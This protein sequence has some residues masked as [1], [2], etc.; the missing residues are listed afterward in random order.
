MLDITNVI[1]ISVNETPAGLSEYQVNNVCLFTTDA[2]LSNPDSD[3][4]RSYTS[5]S[6]VGVDFG[7]GTETYQQAIALF[8]QQPNILNGNGELIIAPLASSSDGVLGAVAVYTVGSGYSVDDVLTLAGGTGGTAKVTAVNHLGN[9]LS[10][11]LLT[12]GTG[13]TTTTNVATTV[14]PSGGTSATLNTT[15][16]TT[17]TIVTAVERVQALVFFVGIISTLY[18]SSGDMKTVADA[19]QAMPNKILI[20][21]S[22]T[23]GDIAGAF[24]N[25]KNAS[26]DHT[27]CLYHAESALEA[28][29][30]AAAYAGVLF[31]PNYDAANSTLTMNLK[32]LR[33]IDPDTTI[34]QTIRDAAK[35]AGVDIYPVIAG[36][37]KVLSSSANNDSDVVAG[38]IWLVTQLQVN[39]FNALA[40]T[41]T[42]IPQTEPGVTVLKSAYRQALL[43]AVNNA[44]VAAGT[45]TSPDTF[46]NQ[47]DFLENI[48]NVGFYIYSQPVSAQSAVDRAAH[49]APVIQIAIKLAGWIGSS[50]VILNVNP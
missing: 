26:D 32:E 30:F 48:Q 4:F 39:G 31:S 20:L 45:W 6:A 10:V 47:V 50:N 16:L 12:G 3:A 19:I 37:G 40:Q 2:F 14:A 24:T 36:L 8:S 23:Y 43:E 42:K 46:G 27:R 49:K 38:I 29:L 15:I 1:N 33:T 13:Y 22:T 34:N 11:E 25:I 9:I 17:E 44:F 18:P 41:N 5:A 21:P 7:T 28:R 35:A